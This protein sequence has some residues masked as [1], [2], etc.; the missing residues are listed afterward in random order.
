MKYEV[1]RDCVIKG[2]RH[3]VGDVV[4]DLSEQLVKDL[5]AIGR[6]APHHEPEP[7]N[8][9]IGAK[10]SESAPKKRG[11]PAKKEAEPEAE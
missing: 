6:L 5:M 11:R 8:R 7:K 3:K 1:I 4:S 2:E 9:A 10:D